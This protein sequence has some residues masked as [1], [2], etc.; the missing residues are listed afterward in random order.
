MVQAERWI[1]QEGAEQ[2]REIT[3]IGGD[4]V[5]ERPADR[6]VRPGHGELE[7]GCA[8]LTTVGDEPLGG[9]DV[10]P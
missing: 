4:D 7:L 3:L 2:P 10:V 9:P 1:V 5:R 8:E 6:S